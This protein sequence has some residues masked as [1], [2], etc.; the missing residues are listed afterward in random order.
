MSNDIQN[1]PTALTSPSHFAYQAFNCNG[2]RGVWGR[3]G[4]V[5]AHT[6]GK[7]FDVQLDAMPLD[8]RIT[9]RV[10]SEKN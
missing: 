2:E 10:I 6:D 4:T 3:I 8:G 9:L 1:E 5:C 7:G